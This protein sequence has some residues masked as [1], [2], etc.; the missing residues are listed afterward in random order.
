MNNDHKKIQVIKTHSSPKG[1]LGFMAIKKNSPREKS[2]G[3]QAASEG[4]KQGGFAR[5]R[6]THKCSKRARLG[7]A[8][9]SLEHLLRLTMTKGDRDGQVLPCE[10]SR[11]IANELGLGFVSP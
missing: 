8:G 9:E 6:G 10:P 2:I 3:S 4:I 11:D 5:P 1:E 7:I